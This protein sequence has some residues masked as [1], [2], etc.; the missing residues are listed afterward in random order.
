M[1]VLKA[2]SRAA[3]RGHIHTPC[4]WRHVA[5]HPGAPTP[6]RTRPRARPGTR[7]RSD[8]APSPA[9]AHP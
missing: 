8:M 9:A 5:A 6:A 4:T 2:R 1:R 3:A 7:A